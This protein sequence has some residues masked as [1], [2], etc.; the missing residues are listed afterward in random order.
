MKKPFISVI[1]A[2][3]NYEEYIRQTLASLAAQDYDN[4]EVII[5]DDGSKDNSLAVIKEYTGKYANFHLYQH[6]GGVNKGLAETVKLAVSKA[7]GDYAAFCESDDY[8]MPQHLSVKAEYMAEHPETA[9]VV[10]DFEL[11]G[12]NFEA[13]TYAKHVKRLKKYSGRKM[14][15]CFRR[16]NT[17]PTFSIAAVK[18]DILAACNFDSPIRACLDLWLWRQIAKDHKI[19]FVDEKLSC[20]RRHEGSYIQRS[21]D[22]FN[23]HCDFIKASNDLIFADSPLKRYWMNWRNAVYRFKKRHHL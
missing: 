7:N 12:S 22:D 5:V 19:G 17:I 18:K 6:E 20:F 4:F 9:I 10:N 23:R 15:H 11:V 3:Y 21:K 13:H 8:W 1:V 16:G 2:S 14:F